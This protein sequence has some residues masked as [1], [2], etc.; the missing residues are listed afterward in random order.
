MAG[1]T[2][3]AAAVPRSNRPKTTIN[4]TAQQR[5]YRRFAENGAD[6]ALSAGAFGLVGYPASSATRGMGL[7]WLGE[8]ALNTVTGGAVSGA[9]YLGGYAAVG[10]K[11]PMCR[12]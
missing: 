12:T 8:K 6:L 9:G 3:G 7:R 11:K 2:S 4:A 5:E 10:W 1:F